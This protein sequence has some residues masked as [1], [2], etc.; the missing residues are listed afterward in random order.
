M[1]DGSVRVRWGSSALT[2]ADERFFAD[3]PWPLTEEVKKM[4][5]RI[6][7]NDPTCIEAK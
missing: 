3:R 2:A 5:M 1:R 4:L 7:E 6:W